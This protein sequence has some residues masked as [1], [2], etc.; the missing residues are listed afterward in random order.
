MPPHA[1]DTRF[2]IGRIKKIMQQDEDV[3]V[4]LSLV[5]LLCVFLSRTDL[6]QTSPFQLK[7]SNPSQVGK[8]AKATPVLVSKCL[9][10]LIGIACPLEFFFF[11]LNYIQLIYF[12]RQSGELVEKA[13]AATMAKSSSTVSVMH[14]RE[15]VAREKTFDFL[16]ASTCPVSIGRTRRVAERVRRTS[17]QS[18]RT[19]A[20]NHRAGRQHQ[21][22]E[23]VCRTGAQ[24][25]RTGALQGA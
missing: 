6:A 4:V 1:R 22:T 12:G 25:G 19:R 16:Q 10:L 18:G 15:A 24:G 21:R 23:L 8:I 11:S 3:G 14:L 9:E 5:S 2:P 7:N 20:Q 17:A 13:S